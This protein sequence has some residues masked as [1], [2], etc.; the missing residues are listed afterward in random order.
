MC[1]KWHAGRVGAF[2]LERVAIQV[3]GRQ[4]PTETTPLTQRTL[5]RY[6]ARVFPMKVSDR[7]P[8]E[9]R[10]REIAG[11]LGRNAASGG[12]CRLTLSQ[13][14]IFEGGDDECI[15]ER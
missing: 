4:I 14:R 12:A 8:I 6:S 11:F 2:E 1:W 15:L 3:S 7:P 5:A 13:I 9:A 10:L